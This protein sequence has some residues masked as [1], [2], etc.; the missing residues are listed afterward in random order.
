MQY[1][2]LEDSFQFYAFYRIDHHEISSTNILE[3]LNREYV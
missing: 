1:S 3:R 2:G